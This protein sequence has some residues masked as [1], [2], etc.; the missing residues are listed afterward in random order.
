M[1]GIGD[2]FE[3]I[4]RVVGAGD[5]HDLD[6]RRDVAWEHALIPLRHNALRLLYWIKAEVAIDASAAAIEAAEIRDQLRQL[7]DD[8]GVYAA[9][10]ST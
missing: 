1:G 8:F 4:I 10:A 5:Q 9:Q 6:W 7:A 2:E 3:A